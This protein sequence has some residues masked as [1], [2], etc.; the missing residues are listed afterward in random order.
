MNQS[1]PT[2]QLGNSFEVTSIG[3]NAGRVKRKELNSTNTVRLAV[4]VP[5]RPKVG[6]LCLRHTNPIKERMTNQRKL[7]ERKVRPTVN[8]VDDGMCWAGA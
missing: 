6:T 3:P 8:K 7:V 5:R 2:R 1:E 4:I